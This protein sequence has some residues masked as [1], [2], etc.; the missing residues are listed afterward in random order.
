MNS[1]KNG[2]SSQTPQITICKTNFPDLL[3]DIYVQLWL[4]GRA[5][6]PPPQQFASVKSIELTIFPQ[7]YLIVLLHE[8]IFLTF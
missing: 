6:P 5:V 2:G 7:R 3:K 4:D 8:L 1:H